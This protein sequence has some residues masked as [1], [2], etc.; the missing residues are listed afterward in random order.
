MHH[1]GAIL[2][3]VMLTV[4]AIA[5]LVCV[6]RFQM[7]KLCSFAP[8]ASQGKRSSSCWHSSKQC[9]G[10]ITIAVAHFQGDLIHALHTAGASEIRNN[11]SERKVSETDTWRNY[12]LWLG[13]YLQWFVS[14]ETKGGALRRVVTKM[15]TD[16]M[17]IKKTK[18]YCKFVSIKKPC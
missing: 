9:K 18:T 8:V 17:K 5:H 16:E 3:D 15:Q 12:S 6:A 14:N 11:Q 10:A 13:F 7:R 4:C 1:F 2:N